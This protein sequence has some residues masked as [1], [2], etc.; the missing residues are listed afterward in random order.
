MSN[1][2]L[3]SQF[4]FNALSVRHLEPVTCPQHDMELDAIPP[5]GSTNSQKVVISY[6]DA[7]LHL[8]EA[9]ALLAA[10]EASAA[11]RADE[12]DYQAMDIEMNGHSLTLESA[13]DGV[14]D[15]DRVLPSMAPPKRFYR[16][17]WHSISLRLLHRHSSAWFSSESG[18]PTILAAVA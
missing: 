1:S 9:Y 14:Y 7:V 18:P 12:S 6:Q 16:T 2:V 4:T 15:P 17:F 5:S 13:L 3:P 11:L 10:A 8:T